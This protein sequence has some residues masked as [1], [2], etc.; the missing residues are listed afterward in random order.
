VEIAEV[1]VEEVIIIIYS[2]GRGGGRGGSSAP[3]QAPNKRLEEVKMVTKD[4][5]A[6]A[7]EVVTVSVKKVAEINFHELMTFAKGKSFLAC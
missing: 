7:F 2:G 5:A 3:V 4:N 1:G 6:G